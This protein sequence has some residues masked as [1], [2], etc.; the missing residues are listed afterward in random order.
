MVIWRAHCLPYF[1]STTEET[2]SLAWSGRRIQK[3]IENS[4]VPPYDGRKQ[5]K[6]Y[7]LIFN[8]TKVMP[9]TEYQSRL[10]QQQPLVL[11]LKKDVPLVLEQGKQMPH[12]RTPQYTRSC[13]F[14]PQPG[15]IHVRHLLFKSLLKT[16]PTNFSNTFWRLFTS[17][18]VRISPPQYTYKG[19]YLELSTAGDDFFR[20]CGTLEHSLPKS[21][22]PPFAS[23]TFE[24]SSIW[25]CMLRVDVEVQKHLAWAHTL[26]QF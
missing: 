6:F 16:R 7:Q 10:E 21:M 17:R 18:S 15:Y 24:T 3:N 9:S 8:T 5:S 25:D 1:F 4:Y 23:K 14:P 11:N 19:N 2:T 13:C 12:L 22:L 20:R 26:A